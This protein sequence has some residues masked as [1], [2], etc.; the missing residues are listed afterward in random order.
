LPGACKEQARLQ[1][2]LAHFGEGQLMTMT[3]EPGFAASGMPFAA[4]AYHQRWLTDQA[5]RLFDFFG[6][7]SINFD[8]G[9]HSLA[10]DGQPIGGLPR[11]LFATCRMVNCFAAGLV[12]GHPG[13]AE[14]VDHGMAFLRN[15][16]RDAVHGG[17]VW[18]IGDSGTILAD[19]LAYGHAF[20]LL[21][22]A[23]AG[24]VG[25]PA[26]RAL[27]D[28]VFAVIRARFWDDAAGA[29]QDEFRQD[30][31]AFS[32]YRGQNSNMHMTEALMAAWEAWG[33]AEC[34]TMAERIAERIINVNA[35]AAGWV[36]P[37]HFRSDWTV[38][39]NYAGDPMFRPAGTTPGHALEWSRLL[40]QLWELGGRT[41]DWMPEAARHLFLKAVD[42]GWSEPRGGF[43][44]TLDWDG[45]P[46]MRNRF[47][48]P[49][50]EGAAA[51][52][53][54][55]ASLGDATFEAWYRLI[56]GVLQR[57]FIDPGHGGWWAEVDQAGRPLETVFVGKPDIYHALGACLGPL[58]PPGMGL[59][60]GLKHGSA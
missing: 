35:R 42:L 55:R 19:K 38:D 4:R 32:D 26:A 15:A 33:E 5:A 30:W 52:H 8:G 31:T 27:H 28:D 36:V 20:V 56:W 10:A 59:L 24:E 2:G 51:A 18:G 40:I 25:H 57:D 12:L 48:W 14:I 47:W 16:H 9:F 21:A 22:A 46:A 7:T 3:L 11:E 45:K 1:A 29:V 39:R 37:E 23:S 60:R 43:F 50:T 53:S 58:V 17:Y 54:L 13:A 34:L 41:K 6:A 44:Y 49:A